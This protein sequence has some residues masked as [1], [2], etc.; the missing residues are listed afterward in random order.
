LL[1][2]SNFL[3]CNSGQTCYIRLPVAGSLDETHGNEGVSVILQTTRQNLILC[4]VAVFLPHATENQQKYS[5]L[6]IDITLCEHGVS[7]YGPV[8]AQLAE[9]KVEISK[10]DVIQWAGSK[11]CP[12]SIENKRRI[13]L[14]CFQGKLIN[15]G[16]LN[17]SYFC[18]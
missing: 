8:G 4:G 14:H 6:I 17:N 2:F 7:Q 16:K 15:S 18:F 10:K 9:I 5:S 3:N 12:M 1:A 13:S 11:G